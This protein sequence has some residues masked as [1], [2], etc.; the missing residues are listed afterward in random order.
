MNLVQSQKAG[1]VGWAVAEVSERGVFIRKTVAGNRAG[2]GIYD[3]PDVATKV[4]GEAREINTRKTVSVVV[5]A[6]VPL[7]D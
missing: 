5:L 3:D 6:L 4:A 1:A 7:R 2:N